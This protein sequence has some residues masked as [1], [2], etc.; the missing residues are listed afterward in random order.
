MWTVGLSIKIIKKSFI[1][2]VLLVY[3]H[4][5]MNVFSRFFFFKYQ[6][7]RILMS[8]TSKKFYSIKLIFP[9]NKAVNLNMSILF[10]IKIIP[11]MRLACHDIK[12]ISSASFFESHHSDYKVWYFTKR[13]K[14]YFFHPVIIISKLLDI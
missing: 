1:I 10:V 13:E 2:Y 4:V 9:Y 5:Y 12:L 11:N 8:P 14:T 3:I 7:K 6:T